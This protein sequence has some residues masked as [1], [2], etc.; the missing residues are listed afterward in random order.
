MSLIYWL[1]IREINLLFISRLLDD[2]FM[3]DLDEL[4]DEFRSE[5]FK[6]ATASRKH[7]RLENEVMKGLLVQLSNGHDLSVTVLEALLERK[8]QSICQ[9]RSAGHAGSMTPLC[10]ASHINLTASRLWCVVS[11]FVPESP[12][13]PPYSV[14]LRQAAS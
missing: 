2:S 13:V 10:S 1:S 9:S 5:L 4:S 12:K 14:W 6:L 7:R 11:T 3:D 8:A